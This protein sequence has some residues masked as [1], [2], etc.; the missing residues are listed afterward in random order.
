MDLEKIRA[1]VDRLDVKAVKL[2][3]GLDRLI[4]GTIADLDAITLTD[5]QKAEMRAEC[6]QLYSE[7]KECINKIN[8]EIG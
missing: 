3:S 6:L 1:Q 5:K 2:R 7:I 8:S 4:S